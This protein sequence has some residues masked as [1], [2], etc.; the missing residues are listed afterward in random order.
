MANTLTFIGYEPVWQ[1][2]FGTESGDLREV[3]RHKIDQCK[4]VLQIVGQCYG[5]EPPAPDPEFGRVS[6]TQYE[7]LYARKCGKKVWY[8]FVDETFRTDDCPVEPAEL[9]ELQVAYRGR[10]QS[11]SHI[12]HPLRSTEG[13]EASVL[14]LRDDLSRLRRGVK[15]WAAAVAVLLAITAVSVLWLLHSQRQTHQRVLQAQQTAEANSA[16]TEQELAATRA[17]LTKN[18]EEMGR[19]MQALNQYAGTEAE[20]REERTD[21]KDAADTLDQRVYADLSKKTGVDASTLRQKLPQLAKQVQQERNAAPFDRA[22]AAYVAKDYRAAENLALEAA[23]KAE[24]ATPPSH[25]NAIRAFQL[26]ASAAAATGNFNLALNHL[27][28]AEKLTDRAS[29]PG[30]WADVQYAKADL[31]ARQGHFREAEPILVP[32]VEART[33]LLGA[34]NPQTLKAAN[35]LLV[36][37]ARNGKNEQ[38]RQHGAAIIALDVQT[39]GPDD[40]RTLNARRYLAEALTSLRRFPEAEAELRQ[41]S[42]LAEKKYGERDRLALGARDKLGVVLA[43]TDKLAEAESELRAVVAGC[44]A[45][46]GPGAAGTLTARNDLGGALDRAGKH[47]EAEAE[48]RAVIEKAQPRFAPDHRMV[49][50]ARVNL[51]QCLEKQRKYEHA[52]AEARD[53]LPLAERVLGPTHVVTLEATYAYAASVGRLGQIDEAKSYATRGAQTAHAKLTAD[54]PL[55]RSF[56]KLVRELN[57][58]PKP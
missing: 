37:L 10:L 14:K 53:A 6:Y 2:I 20:A 22:T 23:K 9:R 1:E 40:R 12:F 30:D 4:G 34:A 52:A 49:I 46:E 26:A 16:R 54:H 33:Q 8:L 32:V 17:Q 27:A 47:G 11:E 50:I 39:F 48:Y 44:E 57:E 24:S 31:F 19:L 35:E 25:R 5:A 21:A 13:L 41:V 7:A 18:S 45:T 3:L 15:W 55:T 56:D 58:Q 28:D 42:D 43:H 51:A 36:A 29:H 38:A